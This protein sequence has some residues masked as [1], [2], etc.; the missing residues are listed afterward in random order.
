MSSLT[1]LPEVS[2]TYSDCLKPQDCL[3]AVD[4]LGPRLCELWRDLGTEYELEKEAPLAPAE[5]AAAPASGD[6]DD[7]AW[8]SDGVADA[9]EEEAR[10]LDD[11]LRLGLEL[12]D[13]EDVFGNTE[14][15]ATTS[16][17]KQQ[18]EDSD[19][20]EGVDEEEQEE[21]EVD[22]CGVGSEVGVDADEAH[23]GVVSGA[24]DSGDDDKDLLLDEDLQGADFLFFSM[25]LCYFKMRQL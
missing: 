1:L 7:L 14:I 24:Q 8:S 5:A 3:T 23:Q 13:L 4:P 11:L 6:F 22:I 2:S 25:K 18:V 15:D 9:A 21:Q 12:G 10:I 19:E 16:R 20:E 17:G